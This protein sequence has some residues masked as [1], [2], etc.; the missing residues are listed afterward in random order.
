M[1]DSH[2]RFTSWPWESVMPPGSQSRKESPSH[3]SEI[4]RYRG[5]GAMRLSRGPSAGRRCSP[6]HL[7]RL[8]PQPKHG[9]A[10]HP[11]ALGILRHGDQEG[12]LAIPAVGGKA[13]GVPL[14]PV[15]K[16]QGAAQRAHRP[17]LAQ[18]PWLVLHLHGRCLLSGHRRAVKTRTSRSA[19]A[20]TRQRTP[21][22][23]CP[24][25]CCGE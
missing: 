10:A 9:I 24:G 5:A 15:G 16:A 3:P 25:P 2:G 20:A 22:S 18:A 8:R 17:Q 21:A 12:H 13:E 11:S 23:C 6:G 14:L 4:R 19:Y 1:H 7:I